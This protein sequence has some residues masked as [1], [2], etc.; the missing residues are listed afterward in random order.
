MVVPITQIA[1]RLRKLVLMLSSDQPGEIVGAARAID[2][3]LRSAGC[4]WHDLADLVDGVPASGDDQ[5]R[6]WRSMRDFCAQRSHL[7]RSREQAFIDH[8]DSWRGELTE[9]QSA[10]LIAIYTRVKKLAA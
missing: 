7:L 2:R 10:W 5:S 9:K 4:N 3:T 8:I 6:N 1:E